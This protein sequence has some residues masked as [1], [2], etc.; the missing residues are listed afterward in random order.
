MVTSM[1]ALTQGDQPLIDGVFPENGTQF[2]STV[3]FHMKISL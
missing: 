2:T 3:N 1:E